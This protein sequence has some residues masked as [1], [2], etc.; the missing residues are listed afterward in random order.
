MQHVNNCGFQSWIDGE[1]PETLLNALKRLWEMYHASNFGRMDVKLENAKF[2][3]EICDEKKL[4]KKKYAS[5]LEEVRKFSD[6][7]KRRV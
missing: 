2:I 1:W 7:T 6:D 5:L 3:K 4:I